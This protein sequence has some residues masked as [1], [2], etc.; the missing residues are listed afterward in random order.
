M[1]NL[2]H[3]CSFDENQYIAF[4]VNKENEK[5]PLIS[6]FNINNNII[7]WI[8]RNLSVIDLPEWKIIENFV[9]DA[10]FN[11]YPCVPFLSEFS[12]NEMD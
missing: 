9:S 10:Y 2:S 1:L 5:I 3:Y 11:N 4:I 12:K 7:L 6:E 8:N